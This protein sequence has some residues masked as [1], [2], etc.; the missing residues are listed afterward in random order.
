MTET[1]IQKITKDIE[2]YKRAIEDAEGALE[3]AERELAE[4]LDMRYADS[5]VSMADY[6]EYDK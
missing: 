3:E 5:D 1:R 6:P 4:E 2:A